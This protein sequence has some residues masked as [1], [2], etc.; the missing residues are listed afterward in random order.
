MKTS[1]LILLIILLLTCINLFAEKKYP[2]KNYS[3]SHQF[4]KKKY[5]INKTHMKFS[6]EKYTIN[7]TYKTSN[8][9]YLKNKTLFNKLGFS[10]QYSK[11]R[12]HDKN[13]KSIVFINQQKFTISNNLFYDYKLGQGVLAG[14]VLG[15]SSYL[16]G[17]V[18][19]PADNPSLGGYLVFGGVIGIMVDIDNWR[20]FR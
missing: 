4:I 16:L 3:I 7:K 12:F 11:F 14:L 9:L 15:V 8:Y 20:K 19:K 17:E 18:L 6:L 13:E 10:P 2:I 5:A 1:N